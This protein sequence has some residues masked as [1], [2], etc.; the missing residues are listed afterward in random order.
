MSKFHFTRQSFSRLIGIG[1][2]HAGYICQWDPFVLK[3]KIERPRGIHSLIVWQSSNLVVFLEKKGDKRCYVWDTNQKKIWD[4]LQ[5]QGEIDSIS[6]VGDYVC[7][8]HSKGVDVYDLP[9]LKL[10][11][12]LNQITAPYCV[13]PNKNIHWIGVAPNNRR[14]LLTSRGNHTPHE[15]AIANLCLDRN[16]GSKYATVSQKGT[17]VRVW[18]YNS[19]K[20]IWE[21]RRSLEPGRIVSMDMHGNGLVVA[22][23][24]GS[25]HYFNINSKVTK[26]YLWNELPKAQYVWYVGNDPSVQIMNEN[27]YIAD[28]T[29]LITIVST[30]SGELLFKTSLIGDS[31]SPFGIPLS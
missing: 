8:S 30:D 29:G 31:Q 27:I 14:Q 16:D 26:G 18:K 19:M 1:T 11:Q 21:G 7:L 25:I 20:L 13:K 6:N 23:K 22:T 12:S 24:K 9:S 5:T 15:N 10:N 28:G 2:P 17:I 4:V 3:M